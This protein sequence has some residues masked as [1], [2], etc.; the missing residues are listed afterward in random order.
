M[1]IYK[2]GGYWHYEFSVRGERR[3]SS[4][5]IQATTDKPP[6]NVKAFVKRERERAALG[7]SDRAGLTIEQAAGRWFIAKVAGK[8]SEKTT[9]QRLEIALRLIGPDTLVAAIDSPEVEA[10]I[11]ARRLEKTRQ[12]RA[13]TDST[14]NRDL[15]DTTLRPILRYTKRVLKQP[16]HDIEWSELRRRE[17]TERTRTFTPAEMK[18]W[19]DALP[20][21]HR[22]VFDF[23][24]RYGVRLREAFFDP[25][26]FD[27][28]RITLKA[29]DRKNR[30]EH[31]LP[32][33][34]S[35]VADIASR[36]ARAR[37]AKLETIWFRE[38]PWGELRPIHWRA[39]QSASKAA[40]T[41]AKVKDARPAHDLRHHAATAA[42]RRGGNLAAVKRL[43]GHDNIQSTMR[44]AH[45]DD[46]DVLEAL[47]ESAPAPEVGVGRL[48]RRGSPRT[49]PADAA[50]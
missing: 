16:V 8:K 44:Y 30:R 3:R 38:M 39:F 7:S 9:A 22:P 40:Q 31:V 24:S 5:R 13:P 48:H 21:W 50:D 27:G 47:G 15:I 6:A 23:I 36:A 29:V 28:E 4:T 1:A 34:S 37:A 32:I 2:R 35:D 41:V 12:G 19:R 26:Q 10:A 18:A 33:L 49:P 11:Q 14:V 43:L 17:P 46:T 20:E 25:G 42:M 45:A